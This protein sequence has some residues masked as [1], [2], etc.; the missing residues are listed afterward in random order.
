MASALAHRGP[1][2]EQFVVDAEAG[3][4]IRRLSIIDVDGGRQPIPNE[5]RTVWIVQNGEIYNYPELREELIAKGHRFRT[6]SDTEVVLHLYEEEGEAFV[7]R[8][9]GMFATAIWDGRS[10]KLL[11]ARDHLGQKPLFFALEEDRLLFAS[12]VKAILAVRR[13][14][15]EIDLESMHQYLTLRFVPAPLTMVR[16]IRKLAPAHLLVFRDGALRQRCFWRL[17]FRDKVAGSEE[18]LLSELAERL[19]DAVRSHLVSDVEV[20]AHLSGGLDSSSIVALMGRVG[21]GAHRTKTFAVG[22]PGSGFDELPFARRV[23]EHCGTDHHELVARPEL[24]KV[25]PKVVWHLD[26]PS[27]PIAICMYFAAHLASQHV[28][29]VLGGDGGD[30]LFAGFDRYRGVG[31]AGRYRAIPALLRA[32][33]SGLFARLPD[34]GAYKNVTQRLRWL[35]QISSHPDAATRYAAATAFFRFDRVGKHHL[36]SDA[37]WGEFG[38]LDSLEQLIAPF[39]SAPATNDLERMLYT[40]FVTRLPEHSLMLGDRMSMA[41]GLEQRSPFVDH[42]LVEFVATLAPT[43]KIRGSTLKYALRKVATPWLPRDIL[44]RP[45]HGFMLPVAQWLRTELRPWIDRFVLSSHFVEEGLFRAEAIQR[46]QAEHD[47][48]VTDHHV[49]LWMLL[50]LEVW[51]RLYVEGQSQSDLAQELSESISREGST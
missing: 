33:A 49:R 9:R 25:L 51:H 15:V 44:E 18:A 28:K 50:N 3:L 29:V 13:G 6:H 5:D 4:A 23:A 34:G 37:L 41:H 36:Y 10:R 30:E 16:G 8:L 47:S 48:Q 7:E 40:D 45:K 2:D 27:D 21:D 39:R 46:M 14:P 35:D 42:R 26:E 11:L 19:G 17:S 20:G 32:G 43:L 22:V 31:L 12:E 1:D 38:K 24:S